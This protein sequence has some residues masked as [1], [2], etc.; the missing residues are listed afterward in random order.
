[1]APSDLSSNNLGKDKQ[2][3]LDLAIDSLDLAELVMEIEDEFGITIPDDAYDNF[4]TIG[5][6]IRFLNSRREGL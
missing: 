1:M 2:Y 3:L 5:D 4:R 6:V